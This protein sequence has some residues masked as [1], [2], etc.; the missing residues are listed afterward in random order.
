MRRKFEYMRVQYRPPN[1]GTDFLSFYLNDENKSRSNINANKFW[2][3]MGK[4]GWEIKGYIATST[5]GHYA[6]FQ[7]EIF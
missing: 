4:D 7:R 6:I 2:D 3:D 1:S 5:T